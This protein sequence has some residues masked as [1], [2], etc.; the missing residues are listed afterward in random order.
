MFVAF[1]VLVAFAI[2]PAAV[3]PAA[4][5]PARHARPLS[6]AQRNW[7][8]LG[9]HAAKPIA[10]GSSLAARPA[11]RKRPARCHR[12]NP[13]QA[14]EPM[15]RE[16]PMDC[17]TTCDLCGRDK[18]LTFHHLIPK[19]LH[20][21]RRYQKRDT[22]RKMRS[23]AASTSADSATTAFMTSSRSR[24][25]PTTFAAKRHCSGIRLLPGTW[26]G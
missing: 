24:S 21:R 19:A 4:M 9:P 18:P 14:D 8:R 25:W 17:L 10:T 22:K 3:L 12:P 13:A 16:A 20:R 2:L 26:P 5:L 11:L 23:A 15:P 7:R 1:A 6:A